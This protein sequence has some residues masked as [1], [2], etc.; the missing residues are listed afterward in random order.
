MMKKNTLLL[1]AALLCAVMSVSAENPS[2]SIGEVHLES[3]NTDRIADAQEYFRRR[4]KNVRYTLWGVLGGLGF[5]LG[6]GLLYSSWK[7]ESDKVLI[8]LEKKVAKAQEGGNDLYIKRLKAL[9]ASK[10]ARQS[11]GLFNGMS[12]PIRLGVTLGTAGVVLNVGTQI[13][14][15]VG[16]TLEE[17]INLWLRGYRYWYNALEQEV[18]TAF[19]E[20]REGLNQS[21]KVA[22]SGFDPNSMKGM[23][24]RYASQTRAIGTHYRADVITMYQVGLGKLER[25]VALMYL[26]ASEENHAVI[27]RH[28]SKSIT[29]IDRFKESLQY[30]LNENTHGTLTHYSNHTMDLFQIVDETIQIFLTTYRVYLKK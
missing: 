12:G 3:F 7:S 10:Q 15:V 8:D 17:L 16:G 9:A 1:F 29:V 21:R 22:S 25:L 23:S 20:L 24:R 2:P 5:V 11:G 28:A 26:L 27:D 14:N 6:G 4:M 30:D 13:L 19:A 18:R